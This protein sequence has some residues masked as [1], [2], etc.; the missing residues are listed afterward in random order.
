MS[1]DMELEMADL[2]T[3]AI[4][5]TLPKYD[6]TVHVPKCPELL[7]LASSGQRIS[8]DDILAAS[9]DSECTHP[10]CTKVLTVELLRL[11]HGNESCSFGGISLVDM[12]HAVC[13]FVICTGATNDLL[14][15]AWKRSSSTVLL[16]TPHRRGDFK[17][18]E[19]AYNEWKES[20]IR[21]KS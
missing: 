2:L 1:R 20:V 3:D 19:R 9:M 18:W 7:Q 15:D 21:F 8:V 13:L 6:P 17:C 5:I 16:F 4:W 10:N 12:A 14:A 11:V